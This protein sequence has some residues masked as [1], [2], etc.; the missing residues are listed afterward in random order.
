M[1]AFF[2]KML[3]R[4]SWL[5]VGCL[6][7]HGQARAQ[8]S[9]LD[10][11]PP[12]AIAKIVDVQ[13]ITAA[14]GNRRDRPVRLVVELAR[15]VPAPGSFAARPDGA[16]D[17]ARSLALREVQDRVL[18]RVLQARSEPEGGASEDAQRQRLAVDVTRMTLV[19]AVV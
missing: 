8:T 7:L 15:P 3:Q 10:G 5:C 14:F 12:A 13:S 4:L 2:R 1:S 18:D 11:L 17:L 6:M 16:G 19:P 9:V